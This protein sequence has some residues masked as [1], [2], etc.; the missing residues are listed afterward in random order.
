M[1]GE[2]RTVMTQ[3]DP[4]TTEPVDPTTEPQEPRPAPTP[5]PEPQEPQEPTA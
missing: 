3:T 5:D 1:P 2:G 4:I